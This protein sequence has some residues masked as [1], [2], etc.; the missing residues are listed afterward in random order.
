MPQASDELRAKFPG[1][2][3]EAWDVLKEHFTDQKFVIRPKQAGYVATEREWDA[4]CYLCDEWDYGYED[5]PE[6][7]E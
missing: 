7:G 6:T 2:D 3:G 5:L 1:H 4:I